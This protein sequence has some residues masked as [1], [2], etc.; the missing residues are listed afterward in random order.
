MKMDERFNTYRHQLS[1]TD[2]LI[3]NYIQKH[4]SACVNLSIEQLGEKCSVS[5]TTVLRFAKKLGYHGYRD[6]R[7]CMELEQEKTELPSDFISQTCTIYKQAIDE[8]S[9]ADFTALLKRIDEAQNLYICSSGMV[10]DA[11]ANEMRRM[12][13]SADK[14]FYPINGPS[15][16]SVMLENVTQQDLVVM[17]SLSGESR[18]IVELAH[19][20]Q[21]RNVPMVSITQLRDNTLA[22]IADIQLYI[23]TTPVHQQKSQRPYLPTTSF[24]ILIELLYL[25]YLEYLRNKE[26]DNDPSRTG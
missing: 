4:R 2:M 19:A 21:V 23:T 1:E 5:R 10:Q 3:W 16:G 25:K 15:E 6:M 8:I 14:W 22:Q 7:V 26:K 24:F 18:K 11:V 9:T 13:L 17:L 20:L 12:F